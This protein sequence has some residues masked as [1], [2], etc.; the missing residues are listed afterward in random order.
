LPIRWREHLRAQSFP[1][2][3]AILPALA[4]LGLAAW[5]WWEFPR[6][7]VALG[8]ALLLYLALSLAFRHAWLV[9]I[10]ALLPV[11]DLAPW[12]GR[13]YLDESD[14]F[15]LVTLAAAFL[16]RRDPEAGPFLARPVAALATLFAATTLIALLLGLFPLEPLDANAFATYFS[17]YNALRVGKGFAWGLG[18]L[19]LLRWTVPRGSDFPARLFTAGM[20]LGLLGV[21]L[22][23][24]HERWQYAGLLDFSTAYRITASFSSMHTGDSH[25]PAFLALAVPFVWLW[26]VRQRPLAGLPVGL[27][28]LAGAVYLVVSTVTRAA[29]LALALELI[30]LALFWLRSL[31]LSG[32]RVAA[33]ALAYS[34]MAAVAGGVLYQGTQGAFL[35]QRL[36]TVSADADTRMN[37]W[38]TALGM[39][40]QTLPTQVF[41]MGLGRFP[42]TY[43]W[44][45]PQGAR[46]GNF[47]Y[48]QENG[49]GY[50]V[51]GAGETLYLAQRVSVQPHTRYRLALDLRGDGERLSL[52]VPLCEKHL[53]NSRRCNWNT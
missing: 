17:H 28:L 21:I 1:H 36:A 48:A 47:R 7:Q 44:R 49:N 11:L 35:Q 52:T 5:G 39:M 43:L 45:N 50:L 10:P 40:D 15:L 4:L 25:L 6:F 31:R 18:F 22:I 24:V 37:H 12:T 14:L 34:A 53:L 23:G 13:F 27:V 29:V 42:E 32:A 46:P 51:L 2:P 8:A 30:L 19:L 20:L 16:H 26:V 33:G 3:L 9:L 38:Q 41:G